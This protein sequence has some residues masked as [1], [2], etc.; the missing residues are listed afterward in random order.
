MTWSLVNLE[1]G[2][3]S[4]TL[5]GTLTGT[6]Q[7]VSVSGVTVQ[8]TINTGKNFFNGSTM[9]SGG[10]TTIVGS[11]PEPSTVAMLGTG[12]LGLAGMVRRKLHS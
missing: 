12:L 11:V 5:T 3:H 6:A 1:N 8:L 9:I 10:D 4:Y 7:G 2:T